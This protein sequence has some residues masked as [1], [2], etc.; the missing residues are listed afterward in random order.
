M[1][2][3]IPLTEAQTDALAPLFD[4]CRDAKKLGVPGMLVA[5]PIRRKNGEGFLRVGWLPNAKA[6]LLVEQA[7]H[8]DCVADEGPIPP[9]VGE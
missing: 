1:P 4:R 3:M 6:Q 5:Q 7:T 9:G 8:A 2:L